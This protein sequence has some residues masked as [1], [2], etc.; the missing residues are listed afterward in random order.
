MYIGG[1]W[2]LAKFRGGGGWWKNILDVVKF[3]MMI[4][5][6]AVQ[7]DMVRSE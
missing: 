2:F 5:V 3:V 1:E 6:I 7:H 4:I